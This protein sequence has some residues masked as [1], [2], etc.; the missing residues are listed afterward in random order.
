M[1]EIKNGKGTI[2][3]KEENKKSAG[4]Q[5]WKGH[6]KGTRKTKRYRE[7]IAKQK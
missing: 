5:K 6:H 4:Y 7:S 1:R 3:A 2:K